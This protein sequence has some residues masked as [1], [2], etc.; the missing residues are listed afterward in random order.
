MTRI[1]FGKGDSAWSFSDPAQV[2]AALD[3]L[4]Y[5][6]PQPSDLP[7]V[8]GALRDFLSLLDMPAGVAVDKLRAV[9]RAV[10]GK[11]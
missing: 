2:H 11:R 7:L 4:V 1:R 10:R 8:I 6:T 5:G 9:R 3:R